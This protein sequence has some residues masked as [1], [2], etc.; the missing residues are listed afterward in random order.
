MSV[1]E[2]VIDSEVN[3]APRVA[4]MVT[5]SDS[6]QYFIFVEQTVLFE[7]SSLP[8]AL[9]L[10]FSCYYVFHVDYPPKALGLFYF[11]Q[12]YILGHPDSLKRPTTYLAVI[13][14]LNNHL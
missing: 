3:N 7:V 4:S 13:S 6:I 5:D 9:F 8:L 11:F 14:D 10:M 1:N 2:A 12:D